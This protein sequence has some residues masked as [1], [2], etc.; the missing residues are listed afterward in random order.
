MSDDRA[1]AFHPPAALPWTL[2]VLEPAIVARTWRHAGT[3]NEDADR[4]LDWHK[5]W[6]LD[7][8]TGLDSEDVGFMSED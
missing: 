5:A 1:L 3:I 2:S 7:D 6:Q 4:E 8:P